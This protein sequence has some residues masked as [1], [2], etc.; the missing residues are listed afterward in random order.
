MTAFHRLAD[1]QN[2]SLKKSDE[3]ASGLEPTPD[4]Q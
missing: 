2:S 3:D 1:A 4:L